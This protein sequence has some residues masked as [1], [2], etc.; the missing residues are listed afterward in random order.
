MRAGEARDAEAIVEEEIQ[1]FARWLGGHEVLP[2][3]RRPARARATTIVDQLLAE[4]AGKWESSSPRDLHR[5]EAMTRAAINRLL[6]EPTIRLRS[7][8]G[9]TRATAVWRCCASCSGWSAATTTTT[10]P[11]TSVRFPGRR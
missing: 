1:R 3:L 6:H 9:A 11:T 5:V 10:P 4:N 2:T 8:D 7:L